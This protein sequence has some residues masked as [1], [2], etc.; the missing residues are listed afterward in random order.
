VTCKYQVRVATARGEFRLRDCLLSAIGDA[1]PFPHAATPKERDRRI[2]VCPKHAAVYVRHGVAFTPAPHA[3][4]AQA[5]VDGWADARRFVHASRRAALRPRASTAPRDHA[6]R[7]GL[8]DGFAV[9]TEVL[10][11]LGESPTAL[12]ERARQR[13]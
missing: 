6:Y 13:T 2:P 11:A 1:G 4:A 8:A 12:D 5:Y 3:D 7:Q 10:L 9:V